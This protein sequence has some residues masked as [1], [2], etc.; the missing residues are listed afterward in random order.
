MA[1][2]ICVSRFVIFLLAEV[3]KI[4]KTKVTLLFDDLNRRYWRGRL[5]KY[6][7]IRLDLS[8]NKLL[9]YCNNQ[10]RTII[11]HK[12]QT[13]EDLRLTLLHE[14]CHI[15]NARGLDHGATF[16]RKVRRLV[17]LGEPKLIEDAERCDG[18]AIAR[19]VASRARPIDEISFRDAVTTDIDSLAMEEYPSSLA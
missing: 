10:R 9:G 5:P 8:H 2:S 16:Q 19:Y 3:V 1:N 4:V 18:T 14:M 17:N 11:L 6:R 7:V 15:G 12:H 13:G